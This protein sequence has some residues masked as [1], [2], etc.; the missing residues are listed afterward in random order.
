MQ[1]IQPKLF[2][3]PL[4]KYCTRA[5]LRI[6]TVMVGWTQSLSDTTP[7]YLSLHCRISWLPRIALSVFVRLALLLCPDLIWHSIACKRRRSARP[8]AVLCRRVHAERMLSCNLCVLFCVAH[9]LFLCFCATRPTRPHTCE[10]IIAT[11]DTGINLIWCCRQICGTAAQS[12]L[13]RWV[14]STF[15]EEAL[16][17]LIQ[18]ASADRRSSAALI[19]MKY[20]R[21]FVV[22]QLMFHSW[23]K[24][25]YEEVGVCERVWTAVVKSLD[26]TG[27][28]SSSTIKKFSEWV[29][30]LP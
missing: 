28:S 22:I 19:Q 4:Y 13:L 6:C 27:K 11:K 7:M 20:D 5:G 12:R 23:L 8:R 1:P 24:Y 18:E 16:K 26:M 10:I 30:A 21:R 15:K 9:F 2:P 17:L 25:A 3:S 14:G 29:S